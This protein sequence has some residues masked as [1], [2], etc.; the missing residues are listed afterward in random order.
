[1]KRLNLTMLLAPFACASCTADTSFLTEPVDI[2][3]WLSADGGQELVDPT[4]L[5]PAP[6]SPQAQTP[7]E[8][9]SDPEQVAEPEDDDASRP[10]DLA[11]VLQLAG[12]GAI[13]IAL[14]RSRAKEAAHVA[15]AQQAQALP[16]L[17]PRAAFFRHEGY[18]QNNAGTLFNV[19]RQTAT[20]G[21]GADLVIQP[22]EAIYQSLAAARRADAASATYR[23]RIDATLVRAARTYFALATSS[24]RQAIAG[25]DLRAAKEL[26]RIERAR[27]SA[28]V[29]LAASVARA[30]A[31]LAE[32]E[33]RLEAAIG[34][35][36]ANSAELTGLLNLQTQA[37]L[38]P[39]IADA[40]VLIDL[41]DATQSNEALIALALHRNPE[42]RAATSMIAAAASE[43]DLTRWGWLLPELRAGVT[44][45]QFGST[46]G[47]TND[48]ENY[49]AGVAWRLDFG[50][51]A[52]H[53]A[54]VER[55]RQ[56]ELQATT[57]RN[58]LVTTIHRLRAQVKAA[59]ARVDAGRREIEAAGE[60]FRLVT[61]QHEEG[62][63]LLLQVLDAQAALSR[64]RI[65][66]VAAV[67]SH[68]VAQYSLLRA[69]GG[70][71]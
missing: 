70:K 11:A 19:D 6:T 10:I 61:A 47:N 4:L 37:Q 46:F 7:G 39:Q 25:D 45:D 2:T 16:F 31:R 17:S 30:R 58:Q 32:V 38:S 60:S 34:E 1:M 14:A 24:A 63:G 69:V 33:G 71:R 49:Y 29:A 18:N 50:M 23:A 51:A 68:N 56:A 42:L 52:R 59:A 22:S 9:V 3:P 43:A 65:N 36:T 20:A 41:V 40:V 53:S 28:G 48:R 55:Q 21:A 66:L 64:A 57:V 27:E 13:D 26:L 44:F 8:F 67:G 15:K 5:T 12:S 62:A 35:V 54:N